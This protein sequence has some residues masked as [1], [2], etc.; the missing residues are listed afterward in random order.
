MRRLARAVAFFLLLT[1]PGPPGASAEE[2]SHPAEVSFYAAASLR[3]VL[4]DLAPGCESSLGVRLVFNLGASNDLARQIMV[5][6]VKRSRLIRVTVKVPDRALAAAIPNQM[7]QQYIEMT[8]AQRREASEAASRSARSSCMRAS[9][10]C[11]SITA[12]SGMRLSRSPD[13]PPERRWVGLASSATTP[14][15]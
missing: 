5:E 10:A 14:S 12:L 3:D 6:P 4:Q 11:F 2:R 13:Y 1:I 15:W 9:S 8:N 7:A